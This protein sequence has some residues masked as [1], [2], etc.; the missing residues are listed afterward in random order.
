M[1][2]IAQPTMAPDGGPPERGMED[3]DFRLDRAASS[4]YSG[5]TSKRE[6]VLA[7]GRELAELT[8]PHVFPPVGYVQGQKLPGNNQSANAQCVN[9]LASKIMFLAFPPGLPIMRL[10]ALEYEVQE[11][12]DAD[13]ELWAKMVLA[14][15]RLEESHRKRLLTTPL[16]T[17]YTGY[18]TALL[19][20]GNALWKHIELD[21]PTYHMP[22]KYVVKRDGRGNPL[23][24]IH[25]ECIALQAADPKIRAVLMEGTEITKDKDGREVSEWEQEAEVYSVCKL[26]VHEDGERTWLYWQENAKGTLVPDSEVETDYDYPPMFPGWLIPH[27]GQDWGWAYCEAYRGDLYLVEQHASAVND[28]ASLA[29]LAL[30]FVKPGST[31]NLKQVRSAP[32]LSILAGDASDLSVFRSDKTADLTF[33]VN[34]LQTAI[35][36]LNAAFLNQAAI[37]R[38]GERVTA[39]EISRLGQELD[40]AMGGLYTSI[41]QGSQRWIIKRF[42]RLNEDA[43]PKLPV[44]PKGLVEVQVVTGTDALGGRS[45]ETALIEFGKVINELFPQDAAKILNALNFARRLGAAKA[46]KLDGL[47]ASD[48][49]YAQAAEQEQNAAA[50]RT[51]LEKGT[52][53]AVAGLA[54]A[55]M[56]QQS[57]NP[58]ATPEGTTLQ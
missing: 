26:N 37:Q 48:E 35:R 33:V 52:T 54:N 7:R 23:L 58:A 49:V 19:I 13:P 46:I 12:V 11:E 34:N 51:M 1:D 25:R 39:E 9:N 42:M 21:A 53:P 14:L 56:S 27:Y 5:M 24:T 30:M 8:I 40:K 47:V 2:A 17:A 10:E 36:R 28:G 43:N 50:Q 57:G 4:V 6:A 32:N 45:E 20:A 18:V 15:S 31:T 22:D 16:E 3:H 44:L 29:A 41:A 38:E 55:M